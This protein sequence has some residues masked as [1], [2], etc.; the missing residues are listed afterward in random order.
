MFNTRPPITSGLPTTR[1]EPSR[2]VSLEVD[3]SPAGPVEHLSPNLRIDLHD[4]TKHNPSRIDDLRFMIRF[5]AQVLR[6]LD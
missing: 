1:S 2:Y 6:C 4:W 3:K 5:H